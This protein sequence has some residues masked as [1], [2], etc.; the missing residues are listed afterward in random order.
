M[1][2]DSHK[3]SDEVVGTLFVLLVHGLGRGFR[4]WRHGLWVFST[5]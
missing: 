5:H 2:A 3:L 1:N 4:D